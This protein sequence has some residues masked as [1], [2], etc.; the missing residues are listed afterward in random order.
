MTGLELAAAREAL[1]WSRRGF[2]EA[3]GMDER[4][5]RDAEAGKRVVPL[6]VAAWARAAAAW[7]AG[8]P[9]PAWRQA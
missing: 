7:H 5:I 3:V 6:H 8:H 2:A 9:P 1:R 4:A